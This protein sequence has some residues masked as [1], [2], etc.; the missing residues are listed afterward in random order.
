IAE[1]FIDETVA[2]IESDLRDHARRFLGGTVPTAGEFAL[3]N[4][5]AGFWTAVLLDDQGRVLLT[6]PDSP[7]LTGQEFDQRFPFVTGSLAGE[8]TISAVFDSAVDQD[9]VVAFTVPF[10]TESGTRV[11]GATYRVQETPFGAYLV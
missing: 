6:Y 9:Q 3:L 11:L 10:A 4:D 1:Q 7:A 5:S 2:G 8:V